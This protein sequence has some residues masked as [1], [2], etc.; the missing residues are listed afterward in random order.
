M[1]KGF[2]MSARTLLT[3]LRAALLVAVLGA[4]GSAAL[5]A[6]AAPWA[7]DRQQFASPRFAQ[8]WN[9]ADLA[10]QQGRTNRSWTWGPHP[11]FDYHEVYKQSPN[12]L[13]L[14]Q[15]FDKAR[16]EI[17]DPATTSGPL[18]GV[19]NGLLVVELVS[20]HLKLGDGIGP[21]QN[22]AL[23]PADRIPVAGDIP[24]LNDTNPT[25]PSYASFRNVATIDNGYRDPNRLGQRVGTT[26]VGDGAIGFDQELAAMPGTDIVA[27]EDVTGHN[28]PRIFDDFRNAGPVPAIAAFGYPITDAYWITARVGG[29]ER[30]VLVQL[31]ER[32]TLTYTPSNPAAFRVEMG[33]VGQHY[34]LWRYSLGQPWA[35]PDPQLPITF[36]SK[37]DGGEFTAYEMD[38]TGANQASLGGSAAAIVPYSVIAW[39]NPDIPRHYRF[40]Y[41]ETTAFTGKR[42]LAALIPQAPARFRV[43]N[44]D[45]ND[46]EPAISPDNTQL[47]FV[48]D[49]DG[50]PDLYVLML[51]P[52]RDPVTWAVMRLT[53]T[54]GCAV[55]HPSW[56]P[57]GSGLVYESNCQG[58]KWA[59]YRARLSYTLDGSAQIVMALLISPQS[60]VAERLTNSG[61]DDRWPRVSPDGSQV[62]FFSTRDGNTEIYTLAIADGSQTRLTNS[63]SRDEAPV[64]SPDGQRIIFNSD[65]DGDH[66]IEMMNRDGSGLVQLTYNNSDDG[67]AVWGP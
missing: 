27:Y 31:F 60:G 62:A 34:F 36:A 67:Y 33:N 4:L 16:M 39:W 29:R 5:P 57:D 37:R 63:P 47:A 46:Y 50:N 48:S 30:Q 49:R 20:G 15:Y 26:F 56:L 21:D 9:L 35:V 42:Q 6:Q 13:R 58:G 25:T 52:H 14:V 54:Q 3:S 22:Q 32:R 17:T 45:A 19:T 55:G 53:D 28:V 23:P 43:L 8:V 2:E 11:W 24:P 12:G 10:V 66:E 41:G 59:I 18:G 40:V 51:D 64:W 65:R 1:Q 7:G 61:G 44:S 38:A